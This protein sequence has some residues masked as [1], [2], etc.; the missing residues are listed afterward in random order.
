MF[1]LGG[2]TFFFGTPK[3]KVS[4]MSKLLTSIGSVKLQKMHNKSLKCIQSCRK[5]LC[6]KCNST[7]LIHV[8][9][10]LKILLDSRVH[11]SLSLCGKVRLG[12]P[13]LHLCSMEES[14]SVSKQC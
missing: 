3:E 6:D 13:A 12:Y 4:K 8:N 5:T 11:H 9:F 7:K 2:L 14:T 1:K 10:A